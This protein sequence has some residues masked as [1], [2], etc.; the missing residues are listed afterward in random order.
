DK[1]RIFVSHKHVDSDFAKVVQDEIEGLSDVFD[2]WVSGEDIAS[3]TDWNR[4]I[5][6][7]LQKSHLLLLLFTTPART[8]DWC[9]FEA[10]LFTRF[11]SAESEDVRSVVCIVDPIGGP[12]R[13]LASIQGTPAT[14]KALA[15]MLHRLCVEPWEMCDDWRRGPIDSDIDPAKINRAA[16][17]ISAAFRDAVDADTAVSGDSYHPCHRIVLELGALDDATTGIPEE[18]SVVAGPDATSGF[19]LSLFGIAEGDP[20][21]RHTWGQVLD[22]LDARES[23]WRRE[24]DQAIDAARKR[25][26]FVPGDATLHAWDESNRS[27]RVYHP[28]LY[29]LKTESVNGST[30]VSA[31]ILLDPVP[32]NV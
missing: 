24:V 16:K 27:A 21:E 11:S 5:T 1:F 20:E 3:G 28:V 10:G 31:E 32:Q 17:R 22:R 12:P 4:S 18:A 14:T 6:T 15:K 2:C 8:W 30:Y 7:A 13:P 23:D 29:S 19:T 9:L 26:L 25:E